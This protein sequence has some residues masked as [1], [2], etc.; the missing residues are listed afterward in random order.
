MGRS[1]LT[2][3]LAVAL[4][5]GGAERA[6]AHGMAGKRFFPA[7]LATE[8]P[9]VA[10][11]LSLPT[12]STFKE[13]ASGDEPATQETEIS[14][15]L[16]KRITPELGIAIEEAWVHLDRNGGGTENGLANLG[17]GLKYQF[18]KNAAHETI[19]SVGMG[20]EIGGTGNHRVEADPFCTLAPAFFFGKGLGDL[21]DRLRYLR[22]LAVTGVAELAIPTRARTTHR[23]VMVEEGEEEVDGEGGA[24]QLEVETEIE[25][26][27][28]VLGWGLAVEYSI[29][30]LQAHVKD[31]G[32]GRPFNR[33]IALVE[34]P[35]ETPLNRG[36][37]GETMGTVNPGILWAGKSFQLGV[38]AVI[39]VNRRTGDHVGVLAQVHFYLDDLFPSSLGRPLFGR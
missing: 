8:D 15:E 12:V 9:F 36:M 17:V 19:A 1:W 14:V 24:A 13:P 37:R 18:L 25:Q 4:V 21:P 34:F 27:P 31:V 16:A 26:H 20:L 28:T 22:P 30:Y 11:E 29:P 33:L 32:L 6:H 38:E 5:L 10:D 2:V 39:P 23:S 7:T 3:L 35:M